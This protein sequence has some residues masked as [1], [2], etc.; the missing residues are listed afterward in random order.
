MNL[1]DNLVGSLPAKDWLTSTLTEPPQKHRLEGSSDDGT[2][3][4]VRATA[5]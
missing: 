1:F 3:N 2:R 4:A 5:L